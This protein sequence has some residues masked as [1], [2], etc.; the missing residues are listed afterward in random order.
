[1]TTVPLV[2]QHA[3]DSNTFTGAGILESA[4]GIVEGINEGDWASAAGNAVA[5]GLGAIGAIMDP[6][7][8]VAS[9]GVGWLI[10]HVDFLKEP[11][12]WL[13]GDAA[14]IQRN[15]KT[16]GNISVLMTE[17]ATAYEQ[18][19]RANL[20]Q[21]QSRAATAYQGEAEVRI[22][23]LQALSVLATGGEKGCTIVGCVVGVVR[24]TVRD[25]I[26]DVV[27][28]IISKALQAI[29][30]VLAPK[31]LVEIAVLVGEV[32]TKI[33]NLLQRLVRTVKR[34]SGQFEL[35]SGLLKQI[36]EALEGAAALRRTRVMVGLFSDGGGVRSK[37]DAIVE[38][39]G[40][41]QG[42]GRVPGFVKDSA[43]GGLLENFA[44]EAGKADDNLRKE[45]DRAEQARR[46]LE[47]E[48]R[49]TQQQQAALNQG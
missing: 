17:A 26:A 13:A 6:L 44:Q 19:L 45:A 3:K 16:W 32:S 27:G 33:L 35:G 28:A 34:L 4:T 5:F 15:A 31:A 23:A 24:A 2:A 30:V 20:G 18:A 40:G 47:E 39:A 41:S 36:E 49:L 43:K 29:T 42:I 22:E 9:A 21:W 11:L 25:I 46:R 1:M 37:L 14:A 7:Q 48:Q 38:V 10:E 12:D 8:A